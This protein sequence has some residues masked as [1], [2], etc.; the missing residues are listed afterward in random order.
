M[1]TQRQNPLT[2][3]PLVTAGVTGVLWLLML[4]SYVMSWASVDDGSGTVNGFG[5][6]KLTIPFIGTLTDIGVAGMLG[7][8][9]VLLS[10]LAAVGLLLLAPG[11]KLGPVLLTVAGGVG[12][13]H[14][15][16]ALFTLNGLRR[17]VEGESFG[18]G[19]ETSLGAGVFLAL[20]VAAVMSVL[21]VYLLRTTSGPVIP[22]AWKQRVAS[23]Q[24]V[25]PTAEPQGTAPTGDG[26]QWGRRS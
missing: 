3:N 11:V 1:S 7:S 4:V 9:I 2:W 10:G 16:V 12:V 17:D 21:A 13:L 6:R 20:V 19:P 14:S 18:S 5:Y 15:V 23:A 25:A 26:G 24:Q 22:A 8:L